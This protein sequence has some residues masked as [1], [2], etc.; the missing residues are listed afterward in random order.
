CRESLDLL[1]WAALAQE[2]QTLA[3]YMG[4]AALASVRERLL[5][6]GRAA[7]TP[8]ALI[9]NGSR[10]EQRVV[11]GTLDELPQR[12]RA[13]NVTSPALLILGEVAAFAPTLHWFGAAPL[14]PASLTQA[15]P[16][17]A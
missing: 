9:E 10:P 7:A 13:H 8:F 15:W 17:A 5:A 11:T 12:A 3:I 1:D 4:V 6:H 16:H 2:R 14:T